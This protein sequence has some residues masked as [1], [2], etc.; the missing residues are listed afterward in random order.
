ME[1]SKEELAYDNA[2]TIVSGSLLGQT[3]TP[4]QID[5]ALKVLNY[6]F[7]DVYTKKIQ[8]Y[9]VEE[10]SGEDIDKPN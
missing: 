9:L 3:F 8:G 10:K 4:V 1:V 2:L 6:I 5:T 7:I